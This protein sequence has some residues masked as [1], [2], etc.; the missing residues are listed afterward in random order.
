M[1]RRSKR[2]ETEDLPKVRTRSIVGLLKPNWLRQ[3]EYESAEWMVVDDL[4]GSP[5][6][7]VRIRWNVQ[8]FDPRR[9]NEICRLS[10]SQYSHLLDT[11]KQQSW[12]LRVGRHATVSTAYTHEEMTRCCVNWVLWMIGNSIYNFSDLD[13]DD[14]QSYIDAACFGPGYL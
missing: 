8:L 10:D 6:P 2:V 12:G 4:P 7:A 13:Q 5:K 3:G 11:I 9:P 1:L 14:F